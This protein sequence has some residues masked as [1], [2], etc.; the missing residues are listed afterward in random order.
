MVVPSPKHSCEPDPTIQI[1]R[2]LRQDKH[3]LA[4]YGHRLVWSTGILGTPAGTALAWPLFGLICAGTEIA[5]AIAIVFTALYG[6]DRHGIRAF[7]L[8]SWILNR[9]ELTSPP[10]RGRTARHS[11]EGSDQKGLR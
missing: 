2:H 5:V 10:R 11:P 6:S 1:E 8:L 3:A 7:R 4:G 9:P